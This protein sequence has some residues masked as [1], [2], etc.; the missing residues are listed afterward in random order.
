MSDNGG[1]TDPFEIARLEWKKSSVYQFLHIA[2]G[3][4]YVRRYPMLKMSETASQVSSSILEGDDSVHAFNA[5]GVRATIIKRIIEGEKRGYI[6]PWY[7]EAGLWAENSNILKAFSEEDMHFIAIDNFKYPE[8]STGKYAYESEKMVELLDPPG[9]QNLGYEWEQVEYEIELNVLKY[10]L[11]DWL[12]PQIEFFSV[13]KGIERSLYPLARDE[14]D[15]IADILLDPELADNYLRK[16]FYE[17]NKSKAKP[18]VGEGHKEIMIH[19]NFLIKY[20]GA[21]NADL[22]SVRVTV[23]WIFSLILNNEKARQYFFQKKALLFESIPKFCE[24]NNVTYKDLIWKALEYSRF[25]KIYSNLSHKLRTEYAG[26]GNFIH[27]TKE[28]YHLLHQRRRTMT[29]FEN[30]NY[31]IELETTKYEETNFL[32]ELGQKTIDSIL[33]KL[34]SQIPI[35]KGASPIHT[36]AIMA[37]RKSNLEKEVAPPNVMQEIIE[38]FLEI[39]GHY[40]TE[41]DQSY[42]ESKMRAAHNSMT[43]RGKMYFEEMEQRML[44]IKKELGTVDMAEEF[45][46]LMDNPQNLV[47]Q[48]GPE[49]RR[50]ARQFFDD[51][52]KIEFT[53]FYKLVAS[54]KS[55]QILFDEATITVMRKNKVTES[56]MEDFFNPQIDLLKQINKDQKDIKAILEAESK[57]SKDENPEFSKES[58][59]EAK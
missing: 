3:D 2:F 31:P 12:R 15:L 32:I 43:P 25:E 51:P 49:A 59:T 44:E 7:T 21:E 23:L 52:N 5:E 40:E 54:M 24:E 39:R 42:I 37:K 27:Y 34:H 16:R 41:A 29:D 20:L 45:S 11:F 56:L 4:L 26:R 57:P 22:Y 8:G 10:A 33:F 18:L 38:R 13:F 55:V 17:G 48:F 1:Y 36:R 53:D 14:F 58:T 28:L 19:T 47:R 9:L 6:R 46:D 50:L 35:P 30:F